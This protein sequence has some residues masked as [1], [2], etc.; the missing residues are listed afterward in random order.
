MNK[1]VYNALRKVAFGPA[2][3][4][5][6]REQE[7]KLKR[8]RELL[9]DEQMAKY[10]K[11]ARGLSDKSVIRRILQVAAG[12]LIGGGV[13]AALSRANPVISGLSSWGGL[14]A[15]ISLGSIYDHLKY[16]KGQDSAGLTKDVE[17]ALLDRVDNLSYL[18]QWSPE[19]AGE[20]DA[21]VSANTP[22]DY[23]NQD[24]VQ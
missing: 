24:E 7:R 5:D 15:G 12:A 16:S 17:R 18:D 13:G 8:L 22:I 3:D 4:V 23:D 19:A 14:L 2:G 11:Y 10:R 20:L 1:R 6:D 21:L 9:S